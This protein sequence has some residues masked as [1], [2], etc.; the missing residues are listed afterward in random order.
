MPAT[1]ASGDA[2]DVGVLD[3]GE[4]WVYSASHV[5]TQ[6]EMDGGT[7]LHNIA[8][9][10]TNH[11]SAQSDDATTTISQQPSLTVDKTADVS[12]AAEGDVIH[13]TI[14]VHNTGNIDLTNVMVTNSL[15]GGPGVNLGNPVTHPA[16]VTVTEGDAPPLDTTLNVGETW[17]YT[18]SH[19]VNAADLNTIASTGWS[20]RGKTDHTTVP[21]VSANGAL[22]F[23]GSDV[24]ATGTGLIQSFLRL[25]NSGTESGFNTNYTPAQSQL[26]DKAGPFTHS[27][28]LG[29]IPV[30]TIGGQEYRE[31]RLDLNEKDSGS[32]DAISLTGLK[33]FSAG[34][35]D[36]HGYTGTG[37]SSGSSTL[38]YNLDSAGDVT[39]PMTE[40]STG[41]GHGDYAVVINNDAFAGL[42]D[43]SFIYLYS[44]FS[45]SDGGFE[46]WYLRQ[47]ETVANTVTVTTAQGAG[48]SDTASVVVN[49][50][51]DLD[52]TISKIAKVTDAAGTPVNHVADHAG[53]VISWT[54]TVQ[55]TSDVNLHHVV[56]SDPTA[57][58]T[59]PSGD[60]NSNGVLDAGETWTYTA[61]HTLT[62][63]EVDKGTQLVNTV[64]VDADEIHAQS[65]ISV[66]GVVNSFV[67]TPG[68]GPVFQDPFTASYWASHTAAWD[69]LSS[70]NAQVQTEVSNGHLFATDMFSSTGGVLIGDINGN[71]VADAGE[72][73]LFISTAAAQDLIKVSDTVTDVRLLMAREA[74]TAQ[75]NIDNLSGFDGH[76]GSKAYSPAGLITQ[77][78]EWLKGEAPFQYGD[79][80]SGNVD[81]NHDGVIAWNASLKTFAEGLAV[82]T[83]SNA[84]QS[85]VDV[86]GG[87]LP[88]ADWDSN[89]QLAGN[90]E[91]GGMNLENALMF[92]NKEQLV[93][94]ND[95]GSVAWNNGTSSTGIHA[96]GVQTNDT[97][98]FWLTLKDA[99]HIA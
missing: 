93:V 1:P 46:E 41:S 13:Y 34:V 51:A 63:G 96:V 10:T 64:T 81:T 72:D 67:S 66:V 88:N 50:T 48:G 43:S 52:L 53:D 36:L 84:W 99:G 42:S 16:D 60:V 30:V 27:I 92:Y 98:N 38:L 21:V 2:S 74:L 86:Y 76:S 58:L 9:V 54:I 18:Y 14:T 57:A 23:A 55:D 39:L 65:A 4:T 85:K 31:F 90:Q 24:P 77:A 45:G 83:S 15:D 87:P 12:H 89:A 82:A 26:D 29:D 44:A 75:L 78:V 19:T 20:D 56:V 32:N 17:T 91:A 69:G 35:A 5:V 3:V 79:G 37:F 7:A 71:G 6:A 28:T 70:N 95:G 97:D 22:I 8:T 11:T 59:G 68:A 61:S 80:S 33:I 94:S 62:Q 25:Q 73:T 40:W 49:A 47:P